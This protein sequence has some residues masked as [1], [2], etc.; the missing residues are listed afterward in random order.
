M[1]RENEFVSEYQNVNENVAEELKIL[2]AILK[3]WINKQMISNDFPKWKL[4]VQLLIFI[5]EINS[6]FQLPK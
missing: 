4:M 1:P 6:D 5:W 3:K 2:E